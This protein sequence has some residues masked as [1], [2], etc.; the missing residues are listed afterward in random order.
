MTVE[1]LA[2]AEAVA[3]AV[4]VRLLDR[5]A[6]LQ[7]SGRREVHLALTG[8]TIAT[9]SYERVGAL[10]PGR[11]I[12]WSGVHLWWSD[13]R[14]VAADSDERNDHGARSGLGVVWEQARVHQMPADDGVNPDSGLDAAAA[15]YD[16][17]LGETIFDICL[18]GLGPD[19]HIASLF[20][21][22][23]SERTPGRVIAVRQSPKP[24]PSRISLTLEVI[25]NS[26][27]VWFVAT[28]AEKAD[29]AAR[30]LNGD[31]ALPSGRAHGS[32][33]T[34]WWLDEAAAGHLD[35]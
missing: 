23:A 35:T 33:R 27:E 30:A 18:L 21:G 16:R 24:P 6:A 31:D 32:S 14:W 5:V 11:E 25:N 34:N 9:A 4:A 17:E 3:D 26:V 2:D 7:A 8:G 15:D 20:P 29:A 13:E 12:N 28:G 10:A 1:V 19:G 22:H